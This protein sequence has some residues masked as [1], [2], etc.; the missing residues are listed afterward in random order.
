MA[1]APVA[2][3][4]RSSLWKVAEI[5]AT[6][7]VPADY[8]D[9]F[10]PLREGADL[11]GRITA[12]TPETADSATITIQPG[13]SWRGHVPGQYIRVGVDIDGVRHWRAY[14]VTSPPHTPDGTI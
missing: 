7:L 6:P 5:L 3:S 11:R 2:G 8:L 14:S 13:R 9:L 10:N 4:V 1:A 12:V